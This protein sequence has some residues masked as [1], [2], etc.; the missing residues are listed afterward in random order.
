M[1]TLHRW[2]DKKHFKVTFAVAFFFITAFLWLTIS[3]YHKY[4][5]TTD[6]A[7]VNAN[8]VH[9]ASRVSG[10]VMHV[11]VTNNQ[12]VQKGQFLFQ[13]DALPYIVA[14]EKAKAQYAISQ[15]AYLNA[16][17][18]ERRTSQLAKKSFASTQANEDAQ[19]TSQTAI[20]SLKLAKAELDQ[21][22][23]NLNWTRITAPTSGYVTNLSLR[24]GDNITANQ[25]LFALISD[26]S[27]WLDANFKETQLENLQAGQRAIIYLDMYPGISFDGVVQSISNG[28]GTVFSLL[29]PQNATGNWVKITQ[30]V[31]VRI[32]FTHLSRRYP[33]RIGASSTVT[34]KLGS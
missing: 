32:L 6:N 17:S 20:A 21:A 5:L 27:Y 15:A 24:D 10:L 28:T 13:L 31:P 2:L 8:I 34:V 18:K 30:R 3:L 11:N 1:V 23:L 22:S 12:Y 7:Y 4:N 26:E 14:L 29:P 9:M 33:L 19:T 16:I 25:P